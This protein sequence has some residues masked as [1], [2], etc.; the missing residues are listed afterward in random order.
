MRTSAERVTRTQA[1]PLARI[2]LFVGF[3]LGTVLALALV[4]VLVPDWLFGVIGV[5]IALGAFDLLV[6]FMFRSRSEKMTK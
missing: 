5:A 6:Y 3:V 1:R 2:A 4:W